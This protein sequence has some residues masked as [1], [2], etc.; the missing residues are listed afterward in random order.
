MIPIMS[1]TINILKSYYKS[2]D[3]DPCLIY[4]APNIYPNI[5][6][7]CICHDLSNYIM[8]RIHY[9]LY[10][11][12]HRTH[13][14]DKA[15]KELEKYVVSGKLPNYRSTYVLKNGTAEDDSEEQGILVFIPVHSIEELHLV[16][17]YNL[18][19]IWTST[20]LTSAIANDH[21]YLN[22]KDL[23]LIVGC[24]VLAD[25]TLNLEH[26]DN[27]IL[28]PRIYTPRY[29]LAVRFSTQDVSIVTKWSWLFISIVFASC[30]FASKGCLR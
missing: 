18:P 28:R 23:A 7:K 6:N 8:N 20:N 25:K 30:Y 26:F 15:E 24:R 27:I 4:K 9:S 29:L 1:Y 22:D 3:T 5:P 13:I 2:F 12:T 11:G 14:L 10:G 21:W 16:L 17:C 19:G